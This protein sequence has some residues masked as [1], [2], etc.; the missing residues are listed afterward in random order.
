M[1]LTGIL[2]MAAGCGALMA[3]AGKAPAKGQPAGPRVNPDEVK[4]YNAVIQAQSAGPDAVIKAA[5]DLLTRF[6]DTQFKE[7]ALSLEA[8]AYQQKGDFAKAEVL[9][10][11]VLKLNPQNNR[12]S[13]QLGELIVT[14]TFGND[15]DKEEKLARAEKLL[16]QTIEELKTAA[17]PNPQVTDAQWEAYKRG[18][19]AQAES[20]LARAAMM[21][22]K[23]DDA[24]A[25]YKAANDADP[26]PAY[27]AYMA[28]ALQ[29]GGK[30]DEALAICTKLLAD[31]QVNPS[32]KAYA[33]NVQKAA[34]AAK[35]A[36]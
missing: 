3:Q 1:I 24:V 17:K 6:A 10:E 14:H 23:Y 12:A 32:V 16:N 18:N 5:D 7:T 15:L 25:D 20:N 13:L 27:Q 2:V 26:Q 29:R 21:R 36:K 30:N 11:D 22:N 34:T 31:P 28:Q 4:A 35:G 9:D 8:A 19:T 33:Q